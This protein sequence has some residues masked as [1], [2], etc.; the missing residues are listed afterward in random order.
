MTARILRK[1][2]GIYFE[3]TTRQKERN[4]IA[5]CYLHYATS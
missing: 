5:L 1:K 2:I 3:V 4:P